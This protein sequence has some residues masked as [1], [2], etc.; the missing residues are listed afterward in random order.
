M[1]QS[2]ILILI[3]AVTI[4]SFNLGVAVGSARAMFPK[5]LLE[6]V[7]KVIYK[8]ELKGES[9]SPLSIEELAKRIEDTLLL[10][11]MPEDKNNTY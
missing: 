1:G 11:N 10:L 2:F 8:A 5:R 4:I 3:L 7:K 6:A 9:L